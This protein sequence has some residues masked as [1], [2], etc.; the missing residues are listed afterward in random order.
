MLKAEADFNMGG[1]IHFLEDLQDFG[2]HWITAKF[3]SI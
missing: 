3:V 1:K 2:Q